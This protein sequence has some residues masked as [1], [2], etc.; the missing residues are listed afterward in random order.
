MQA[1]GC[2][3]AYGV[4]DN[5]GHVQPSLDAA[6]DLSAAVAS[7]RRGEDAGFR[8]LYRAVQ[9]GLLR[10]LLVL[11]GADAEDVASEAWL[12]IVRDLRSFR[13]DGPGFAAWAA[14]VA[15]HR[16]M[17]HLR[18]HRRRPVPPLPVEALSEVA[19]GHDTAEEALSGISTDEA[20]ALIATLPKREAEAVLLRVVVGLDAEAAARVLGI[21]AGAVR[22]AAYRGL[23][24]LA[25]R[26]RRQA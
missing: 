3:G 10:Y 11:V 7:A 22:T 25:D 13:G 20:V 16:A 9:P 4:G 17:D 14:A 8:A 6:D 15:R 2:R 21:Q 12:H 5:V 23:R 24:R 19:G 26:A 18:H 1:D